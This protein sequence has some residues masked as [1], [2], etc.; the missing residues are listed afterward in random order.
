MFSESW[1]GEKAFEKLFEELVFENST[2]LAKG[3]TYR[4]KKSVEPQAG[5]TQRNSHQDTTKSNF[6]TKIK[7][8]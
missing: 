2:N 7:K 1:R 6:K 5:K 4:S 3:K 8:S